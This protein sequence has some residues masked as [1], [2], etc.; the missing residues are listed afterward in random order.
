MKGLIVRGL[1]ALL[2]VAGGF[3]LGRVVTA[4]KTSWAE[5]ALSLALLVLGVALAAGIIPITSRGLS[6]G[7]SDG[8]AVVPASD[9]LGRRASLAVYRICITSPAP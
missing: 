8:Y 2:L 3:W 4:E 9:W 6:N 1:G 5:L 7:C